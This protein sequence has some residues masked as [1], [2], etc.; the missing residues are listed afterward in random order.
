MEY[1]KGQPEYSF[2]FRPVPED[3]AHFAGM[4]PAEWAADL[5]PAKYEPTILVYGGNL[6]CPVDVT[7]GRDKYGQLAVTAL[8]IDGAKHQTVITATVLRHVGKMV[9][10]LLRRISEHTIKGID[11]EGWE[12][13]L[14]PFLD[15]IAVPYEGVAMRPGRPGYSREQ[16]RAWA[17]DYRQALAE[18]SD[19]PYTTLAK[20]WHCDGSI[21]RR[22]VKRAWELFPELR[23]GADEGGTT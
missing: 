21:A 8:A 18:D 13:I 11:D 2:G 1:G 12:V 10:V 14:G 7:L 3:R 22:R 17:E 9:T 20:K 16:Y 6:P 19:P 5:F 15:G 23:P 4:T